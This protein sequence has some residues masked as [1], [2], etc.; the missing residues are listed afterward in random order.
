MSTKREMDDSIKK[1]LV[2]IRL[3]LARKMA[4]MSLQDLSNA[5]SNKVTKQSLNKYEQGLMKP[6]T[7]TLIALSSVLSVK[8]DYFL[9]SDLLE[10]GEILFRKKASLPKRI[11]EAIVEKAR[12]YVER[13]I[14]LENILGMA[15][16]FQNPLKGI[17]VK[18][19]SD[20]E[21]AAYALREAWELGSNP[22]S[23][24]VEMLE[25]RGIKIILIEDV[26]EFDGFAAYSSEGIPIVAVNTHG[27]SIER[28]RFTTIHELAHILLDFDDMSKLNDSLLEKLC[29]YFASCFLIPSKML[30]SMI[31]GLTRSYIAIKELIA[32]KEYFG[33]SI[34]AILHRLLELGVITQTYY[35]RWMVYMTKTWGPRNEPGAFKGENGI[36]VFD[37]LINRA[38][39]EG[40]ISFSKAAALAN[41]SISELRKAYISVK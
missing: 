21:K 31:G 34:R 30:I 1:N 16:D 28:V 8:P 13:Y 6:S 10:L 27:R 17:K 5:L 32:I 40:L 33:I 25:L 18:S 20:V 19:K 23:N 38:L 41:V 11:E 39:S 36:K 14:E 3:K 35:K 24:L 29:H 22:I 2:G 26:D 37:H 12:D 4:G 9:K 15:K 7:E